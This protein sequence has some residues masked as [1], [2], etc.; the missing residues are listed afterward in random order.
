MVNRNA[1]AFLYPLGL[2]PPGTS[3]DGD[4]FTGHRNASD[5]R[6][7]GTFL[8]CRQLDLKAEA[9]VTTVS[10]HSN[11]TYRRLS[12]PMPSHAHGN[13]PMYTAGGGDQRWHPD[14]ILEEGMQW[15]GG[16]MYAKRIPLFIFH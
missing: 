2:G 16:L 13:Y 6:T 4:G 12:H 11:A 5:S 10:V 8:N 7:S 9:V 14:G 3:V 1:P 15:V